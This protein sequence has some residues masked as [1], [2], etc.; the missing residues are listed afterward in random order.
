MGE[1]LEC[2]NPTNEKET[3]M[4]SRALVVA[5]FISSLH[6][7]ESRGGMFPIIILLDVCVTDLASSNHCDSLVDIQ[8]LTEGSF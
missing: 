8:E 1:E 3:M 7:T 2:R 4:V 5:V 6:M